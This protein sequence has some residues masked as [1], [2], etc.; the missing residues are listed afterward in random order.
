MLKPILLS[1]LVSLT[2]LVSGCTRHE[3]DAGHPEEATLPAA[4]TEAPEK[5]P[6]YLGQT[7]P[8]F[9]LPTLDGQTFRLADHRGKVVLLNFWATWCGPCVIETPELVALYND[10]KDRGLVVV[11]ISLDEE[12]FE[13][14]KPF[15]EEFNVTY[16][17]VVDDGAVAEAY[18]GIYGL[19]TTFVLDKE[20]RIQQRFI[21]IFPTEEMRPKLEEMLA[22]GAS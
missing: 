16:P 15:A 7:A 21:G 1:A 22:K 17:M 5:A 6:S 14:V 8:D 20:G 9:T 12:G 3:Q 2:F 13:V 11:G 4:E 10:L 19:P 18:G